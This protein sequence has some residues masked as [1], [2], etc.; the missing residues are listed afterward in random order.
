MLSGVQCLSTEKSNTK[1]RVGQKTRPLRMNT[2]IFCLCLQNE[3]TNFYEPGHIEPRDQS[4]AKRLDVGYQGKGCHML[5]FVWTN[6]VQMIVAVIFTQS[7]SYKFGKIHVFC[8]IQHNF[9]CRE[10]LCKLSKTSDKKRNN[11]RNKLI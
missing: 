2:H 1:Y 7:L 9:T 5:N 8:Q 4:A 11:K 6:S 3:T 10:V